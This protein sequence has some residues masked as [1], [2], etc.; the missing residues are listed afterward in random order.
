MA[1][2]SP[3]DSDLLLPVYR[4]IEKKFSKARA[5]T[6]KNFAGQ[7]FAS[8]SRSE[9]ARS[10]EEDNYESLI[11]AWEFIQ[12]R[13]SSRPK[14]QFVQCPESRD[15][16]RRIDTAIYLL[17]DDMSFVIDSIRQGLNRIG[18]TVRHVNNAVIH[19]QRRNKSSSRFGRLRAISS[20]PQPE[21][22]AEALS[23]IN[24]AYISDSQFQQIE[25]ELRDILKHVAVA[26][27]DYRPMCRKAAAIRDSLPD[28]ASGLPITGDDLQESV[29]FV[30][31]LLN[32]H[33]TFLGYEEYRIGKMKNGPVLVLS[34]DSLLGVSRLRPDLRERI[35]IKSLA[36]GTAEVI[37]DRR[38]C[39]F[40]KSST[41]S[42]IHRPGYYDYI[43]LKQFDKQG[44]VTVVHRF[45]GLYTSSVYYRAALDIPLVRQ[46]VNAVLKRSGFTRNGH[47]YKDLLQVINVFPR[48]ELFLISTSQ[49]YNTGLEITRIQET[50]TSKL[51]IRRDHYGNFFSCLVY[52]PKD[53]YNTKVRLKVQDFLADRLAGTEVEHTTYFS[54]SLLARLHVVVRSPAVQNVEFDQDDLEL[55]LAQLIKPWED[56]FLETLHLQYADADA[57]RLHKLYSSC[58]PEAYKETYSAAEGVQDIARIEKVLHTQELALD[59]DDCATDVGAELNFKI[60]SYQQQLALSDVD[61]ILENLGMHIISETTIKL[62][63]EESEH[64]WLHDFSLYRNQSEGPFDE[65]SKLKFEQ[66]FGAIWNNRTDDD[67]FNMLVVSAG[68]EWRDVALLRAY[69]AYLKQIQFGYTPQFIA[70]TL[71]QHAAISQMLVRYFYTLFDPHRNPAS[72]SQTTRNRNA[73]TAAIDEVVNLAEDSVLRAYLNLVDATLRTNYFQR[74]A[75][76]NTRDYFA[77]K[78]NPEQID[79]MPLPRPKYEIFVYSRQMEGVHLRGGRVARGGLRWSDRKEDYRTEI[80]GLVKAQQV[81]NSLIVPVGAKGGFVVKE[82]IPAGDREAMMN[83]GIRCYRRFISGLLDLT[84]NVVDGKPVPPADVV[85]RDEADTYLV[86]AADKGTASFSDIANEISAQYGFWLRDGFASGGSNGYDHKA[87]GITAR[88][89]WVSTQR[90]FRELG[91]DVQQEDFTVVGIGDMSGDVF[92][93]GMLLSRHIRLVAAFNHLHIFVDPDPDA[94]RSFRERQRLFKMPRSSWSDYNP[95]LISAGGGV[96]ARSAKSVPMSREMQA[97]FGIDADAVTPDQLIRHLLKSPVDLIWNGGIGTYVKASGETHAEVGDKSNDG[98]RVNADTLQARVF[99]EGGNLGMTQLAR[100]E[101]GLQGGISLTD[102]I[103]NSAG[104]DCSDHEVNIKILLNR[105][106]DSGGLTEPRR[107][108]LLTSMTDSVAELVLDNNYS[109]VQAIGVAY[110][111]IA[112]RNKEYIDLIGYL[113]NRAG[114][115][116]E[117]E[118]LPADEEL[119][120]RAGRKQYLTRPELAVL[121]SYTKMYLKARLADI[122]YIDNDYLLPCLFSA[123]PAELARIYREEILDHPLRRE[124]IATQLANSVVNLLGPS[125]VYRMVDSTGSSLGE[126][127]KAAVIARD[128]YAVEEAWQQVE[129]LDYQVSSE[130]QGEMMEGLIR[131]VRRSSRWFL[132]NRRSSLDF[133]TEVDFFAGRIKQLSRLLPERL[134]SDLADMYQQKYQRLVDNGVPGNTAHLSCRADFLFPAISLIEVS[135]STGEK[136]GAVVDIY[137]ALGEELR[138]NW[139]GSNIGQLPVTNYWQALAKETY[140]DDLDWQQRALTCNVVAWVARR[141]SARSQVRQWAGKHEKVLRRTSSMMNHLQT[142]SQ[143]DYAMFAVALRELLN[144][145][146]AT[147]FKN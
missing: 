44:N 20:T 31:W 59:M 113:E 129:S 73:I 69:A 25:N 96:F 50:R 1:T 61:P 62:Q 33:F 89:A 40:A 91:I 119:E 100:I 143:P 130:I 132:R 55:Q 11:N 110:Q 13:S 36:A 41:R 122:D 111:Q 87:M 57:D 77:F 121:T 90:H 67:S 144:L 70:E 56:Y 136:L 118:F 125:F 145:A 12:E 9:L 109:Q 86:V 83:M 120:E 134:P 76:D 7:Y 65:P 37:L 123:F 103:D 128:I 18:V 80:L 16:G 79:G 140:L 68:L 66:A 92:G 58:Y 4:L 85:C 43:L 26:V 32:N 112:A 131:L 46:K 24:C 47:S 107:N 54:E 114:L 135:G 98:L 102:F 95:A 117:L 52:L 71:S 105:L 21:Y 64:I 49:L 28:S 78:F 93:N 75:Q 82:T 5:A 104:V 3:A 34:K 84:D 116:R 63:P 99:V 30:T 19:V 10:S 2:S 138:L 139:L 38:L 45:V 137:Y 6:L 94:A 115:I 60:F 17:L 42:R 27:S 97:R 126:V 127:I 39:S 142:E 51:F 133:V 141:G 74:D 48:D 88:G 101:Y 147:A 81:K 29:E 15:P 146:Q 53:I 35:S 22:R 106:L 124:I 14:I 23:C 108:S 72:R 8:A